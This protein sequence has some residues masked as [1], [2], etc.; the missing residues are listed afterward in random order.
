MH[1][2]SSGCDLLDASLESANPRS[3]S[4]QSFVALSRAL[5]PTPSVLSGAAPTRG[6]LPH[7]SLLSPRGAAYLTDSWT[8]EAA[9]CKANN[10]CGCGGAGPTKV[11]VA[12]LETGGRAHGTWQQEMNR[13]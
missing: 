11:T 1:R 6:H 4:S 10:E 5:P 8:R 3:A 2:G 13:K 9:A 12:Q 7:V